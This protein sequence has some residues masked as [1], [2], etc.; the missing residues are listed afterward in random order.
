[1][2]YYSDVAIV[3]RQR[4]KDAFLQSMKEFDEKNKDIEKK[5]RYTYGY[6]AKEIYD[7]AE[8][9]DDV[10]S[11]SEYERRNDD[12]YFVMSWKY[13]K[14]STCYVFAYSFFEHLDL[15]FD[16]NFVRVGE[17]AGDIETYYGLDSG[18]ISPHV[19]QDIWIY[20]HGELRDW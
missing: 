20:D 6:T 19:E 10:V 12:T 8:K 18:I 1:M 14:W 13:Q 3:I 17:E 7:L 2:G 5:D 15:L 4:D 16:R 9:H 11:Y